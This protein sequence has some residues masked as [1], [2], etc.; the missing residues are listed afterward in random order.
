MFFIVIRIAATDYE[1]TAD[2][3]AATQLLKGSL[4]A[5][6]QD[7]TGATQAAA[8]IIERRLAD[9]RPA[10]KFVAIG[11]V[12]ALGEGERKDALIDK[13]I[14]FVGDSDQL[15]VEES[16]RVL[17]EVGVKKAVR[18]LMEKFVAIEENS[19]PPSAEQDS[20]IPPL[21]QARFAI[22]E[23][24]GK[25]TGQDRRLTRQFNRAGVLAQYEDLLAWWDANNSEY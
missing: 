25:I 24:V 16:A 20:G 17:G 18:P 12:A 19:D 13:L 5:L 22:A 14:G 2:A 8:A 23:A 7:Y 21:N 3:A 11:A 15:I 10:V 9:E 4:E 6:S 1:K